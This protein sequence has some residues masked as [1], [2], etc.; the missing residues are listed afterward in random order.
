MLALALLAPGP[1]WCHRPMATEETGGLD[2]GRAELELS[3]EYLRDPDDERG[4][5][6][7]ALN[8]G[9]LPGVQL[10]L[11]LARLVVDPVDGSRETGIGDTFV[12]AKY[13]LL[14]EAPDLPA[15]LASVTLRLPTGSAHRGL[16]DEGVDIA[17]VVAASKTLG[18]VMVTGNAGYLFATADRDLDLW[19][20]AGSVEHALTPAWT[21]GIEVVAALG[22]RGAPDEVV[23]R[24]G[25][26]WLLAPGLTLDAGLGAGLTRAAQDVSVTLGVT[27]SF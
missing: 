3:A 12:S 1:A 17:T 5:A 15:L 24:G 21:L 19:L 23:L 13:R 2:P 6:R 4:T 26:S 27:I 7:A 14:D 8:V 11:T 16:G 25:A 10:A 20:L 9:V 18:P 22:A